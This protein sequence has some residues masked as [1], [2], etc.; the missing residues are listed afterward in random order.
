M[1]VC[2]LGVL[3]ETAQPD[4]G[5]FKEY[6]EIFSKPLYLSISHP[7]LL[8]LFPAQAV[9]VTLVQME[10]EVVGVENV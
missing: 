1:L 4:E 9:P 10:D 3:D 6:E 8:E 5:S 2:K 7:A